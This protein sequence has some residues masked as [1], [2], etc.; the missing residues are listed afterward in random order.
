MIAWTIH[1][2][3]ASSGLSDVIVTTDDVETAEVARRYG[4]S[5]PG[6]RPAHLATDT[7]TSLDVVRH[8]VDEYEALHGPVQGVL[9]LQPTSPFRSTATIDRAI[10]LFGECPSQAIVGVSTASAHPAWCFKLKQGLMQ[11]F[12]GWEQVAKR[13]QDLEPAYTLNGAI[14]LISPQT[15]REKGGFVFEGAVPLVMEA[16]IESLDI[17]TPE[18]WLEAEKALFSLQAP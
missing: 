7:A 2:A 17:D 16:G 13:S 5:V 9:L 11:P 3:L 4:A 6:L 12:L 18:D 8:V 1:A 15:L 10:T 14:Y